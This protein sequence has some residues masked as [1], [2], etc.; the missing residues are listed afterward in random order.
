[1]NRR[2]SISAILI[3]FATSLSW[4]TPRLPSIVLAD[5]EVWAGEGAKQ[6]RLTETGGQV[7]SFLLSPNGDTVACIVK[8]VP[9]FGPA[10]SGATSE[11]SY[12]ILFIDVAKGKQVSKISAGSEQPRLQAWSG[13]HELLFYPSIRMD[14]VAFSQF[15]V[16]TGKLIRLG[17]GDSAQAP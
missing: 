14:V 12:D 11:P 1:V 8:V 13:E 3:T 17:A 6:K 15:N 4:A 16:E 9:A 7:D 10:A 2:P 5:G